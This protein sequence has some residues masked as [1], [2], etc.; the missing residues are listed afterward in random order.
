[1]IEMR[2]TM[3]GKLKI[4]KETLRSLHLQ[5]LLKAVGGTA[6][7]ETVKEGCANSLPCSYLANSVSCFC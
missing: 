4:S 1:M 6:G 7:G 3:C 2:K 5:D